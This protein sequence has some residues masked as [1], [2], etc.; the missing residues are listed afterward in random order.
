MLVTQPEATQQ[1]VSSSFQVNVSGNWVDGT[2]QFNATVP[3]GTGTISI[4]TG[5]VIT[6]SGTVH[7]GAGRNFYVGS[8]P[9]GSTTA[10]QVAAALG[11]TLDSTGTVITGA[12]INKL[13][14]SVPGA[15]YA[16]GTPSSTAVLSSYSSQGL[17]ALFVA[18]QDSTLAVAGPSGSPLTIQFTTLASSGLPVRSADGSSSPATITLPGGNVGRIE[19]EAGAHITTNNLFMDIQRHSASW[20]AKLKRFVKERVYEKLPGGV[21]PLLFFLYRYV[22]R[23]GFL[24]GKQGYYFHVLQGFWY[25]TLIDAKLDEVM[26]LDLL[27]GGRAACVGTDDM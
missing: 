23:L 17:G 10:Q 12:D 8:N 13:P 1:T 15:G 2:T 9:S 27:C 6:T 21:R 18:S 22:A 5:S 14:V 7:T 19:I 26:R 20:Q 16:N 3:T 24:D 4:A 11:G 25:R